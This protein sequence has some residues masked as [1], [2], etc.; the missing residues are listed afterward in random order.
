MPGRGHTV[1]SPVSSVSWGRAGLQL[2]SARP[3]GAAREGNVGRGQR[4][5][6]LLA[7]VGTDGSQCSKSNGGKKAI[8]TSSSHEREGWLAL[9]GIILSEISQGEKDKDCMVS[10]LHGACFFVE[11]FLSSQIHRNKVGK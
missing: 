2:V 6:L 5:H 8:K 1:G 11:Y 10:L 9:E 7:L 4:V 3:G